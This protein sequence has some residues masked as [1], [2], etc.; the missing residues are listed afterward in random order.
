MDEK[1]SPAPSPVSRIDR[2]MLRSGFQ[3]IDRRNRALTYPWRVL[4]LFGG[5]LLASGV[6]A[7][8]GIPDGFHGIGNLLGTAA[9]GLLCV[10]IGIVAVSLIGSSANAPSGAPD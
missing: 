3:E 10:S 5:L 4:G 8:I 6:Q 7:V 9:V 2:A 1:G